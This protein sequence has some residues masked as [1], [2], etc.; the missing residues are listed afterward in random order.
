MGVSELLNSKIVDWQT[1]T[2]LINKNMRN[3]FQIER[4]PHGLL[5]G[6]LQREKLE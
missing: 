4:T 6:L 5:S 2:I 1:D 3:A